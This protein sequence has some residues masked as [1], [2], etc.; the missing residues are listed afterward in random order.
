MKF[1]KFRCVFFALLLVFV[2]SKTNVFSSEITSDEIMKIADK[3]K[4]RFFGMMA[5]DYVKKYGV[6]KYRHKPPHTLQDAMNVNGMSSKGK[7]G[8]NKYLGLG[9]P[10]RVYTIA[11][12]DILKFKGKKD[13]AELLI[14]TNQWLVPFNIY[15]KGHACLTVGFMDGKWQVVG[16]S[17]GNFSEH[18]KKLA[19]EFRP[20][21]KGG[22]FVR[23]YPA[24]VDFIVV[25]DDGETKIAMPSYS[26]EAFSLGKNKKDFRGLYRSSDVIPEIAQKVRTALD[27]EY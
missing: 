24:H 5:L 18:I 4:E 1:F 16:I 26:Q 15:G 7:V 6:P 8:R 2:F 20:G 13:I 17:M 9:N 25:D 19:P 12:S 22:K 11:T 14:E 23:I 27:V 3:E 10:F 21:G